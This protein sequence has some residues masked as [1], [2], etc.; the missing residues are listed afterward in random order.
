M[1][2]SRRSAALKK[3][4]FL[5]SVLLVL[6]YLLGSIA[7]LDKSGNG[8]GPATSVTIQI[9]NSADVVCNV[10]TV[11]ANDVTAGD[12]NVS[13]LKVAGTNAS[14]NV[15]V[16]DGTSKAGYSYIL[17]NPPL[18]SNNVVLAM[19]GTC[20][21]FAIVA[22]SYSGVDTNGIGATN[23]V[24]LAT[25]TVP[26]IST[27]TTVANAYIVDGLTKFLTTGTV[28]PFSA[29]TLLLSSA[30]GAS[31]WQAASYLPTTTSGSYTNGYTNSLT[32][33]CILTS[34]E[35]KPTAAG[36][37]QQGSWFMEG[38]GQ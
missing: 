33:P 20:S 38:I 15:V 34:V 25:T 3:L 17:F 1:I 21:G 10:F 13:T 31:H 5:M 30:I 28:T 7:F 18:G 22:S 14:R 16:D 24:V 32:S 26:T 36:I 27:T 12:R 8:A 35:L 23:G 29:Q 2:N 4:L 6:P 11:G 37:Q 9:T 19:G